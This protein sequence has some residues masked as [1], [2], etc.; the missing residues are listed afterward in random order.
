MSYLSAP[1]WFLFLVLSTAL[2]AIHKLLEPQYFFQ[3]RQLFPVWPQWH[4]EQA[5]ALFS[6]TL[7]LLFLPKLLSVVLI[8]AK[9]AK[10]FGG[11]LRLFLSMMLEMLFS[12][13]LAPVRMLFHTVFVTAAFLAGRAVEFAPAG[14]TTTRPGAKPSA[15]MVRRC[16]SSDLDRRVA[17]L[18]P[19]FPLVAVAHRGVADP[20][21][22]GV[23]DF[24]PDQPG[25][26]QSPPSPVP[27]PGRVR[28]AARAGGDRRVPCT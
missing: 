24:Q 20:V 9:G 18:D 5:I 23:G 19:R 25:S 22:T 1:L 28:T 14:T 6:T 3:P 10:E 26:G 11:G 16:C 4:P 27:D 21:G 15:A 7:I 8:I 12:V 17:W 13:L 2:L